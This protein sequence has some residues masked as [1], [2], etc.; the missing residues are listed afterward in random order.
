M[1]NYYVNRVM[2]GGIYYFK[3]ESEKK[4]R[5]FLV[6]SKD[7]GY[8]QEVLVFSITKKFTSPE[9]NL[10]IV[11]NKTVS[12]IRVSGPI[13]VKKHTFF[14][15]PFNGILVPDVFSIAI[16]MFTKRFASVNEDELNKDLNRYLTQLEKDKIPLLMN[17][18][19]LFKKSDYLNSTIETNDSS[20]VK[21]F[22]GNKEKEKS[23]N[24]DVEKDYS[25][26]FKNLSIEANK[27]DTYMLLNFKDIMRSKSDDDLSK[28]FG[29][30]H[31]M[32]EYLRSNVNKII[33]K[34]PN[35]KRR[36]RKK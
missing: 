23:F 30:N 11:I 36:R 14:T 25:R 2:Q 31:E 13:E 17:Q 16:R 33:N 28:Q 27:L 29:L 3:Q 12:F 5:P 24:R 9:V 22:T 15:A 4:S 18:N 34:R 7:D 1:S 35:V 32:V 26:N 19:K 8:G 10:P 20:A 21:E 6:I